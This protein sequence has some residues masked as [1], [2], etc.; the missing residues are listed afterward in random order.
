MGSETSDRAEEIGER[1][2]PRKSRKRLDS[3]APAGLLNGIFHDD[4]G[5]MDTFLARRCESA[6][7]VNG[8]L[9]W[10]R[11]RN[12]KKWRKQGKPTTLPFATRMS[13]EHAAW[14]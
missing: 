10:D 4:S 9:I 1:H 7:M 2:N 3:D 8:I 11:G 14:I 13:F 12:P 6:A 5:K